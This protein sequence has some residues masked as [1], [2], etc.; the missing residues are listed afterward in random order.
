MALNGSPGFT[1]EV[2]LKQKRSRGAPFLVCEHRV[3]R[4]LARPSFRPAEVAVDSVQS[5]RLERGRFRS[6]G[7]RFST[8]AEKADMGILGAT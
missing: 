7:E 6:A 3:V 1:F 2:E 8:V 5:L 4:V